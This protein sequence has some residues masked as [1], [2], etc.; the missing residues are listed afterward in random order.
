MR[1]K[2]WRRYESLSIRERYTARPY[3]ASVTVTVPNLLF[4]SGLN[5]NSGT[6]ADCADANPGV[7]KLL[8]YRPGAERHVEQPRL[9]QAPA[10]TIGRRR[11]SKPV[12]RPVRCEVLLMPVP[13][14]FQWRH[15]VYSQRHSSYSLRLGLTSPVPSSPKL[16]R[17]LSKAASHNAER[18]R[19]L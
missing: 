7:R 2:R 6:G 15:M 17:P 1:G 12:A 13:Q 8:R 18:R 16:T 19:P 4:K 9:A 3:Q 14:S 10:C 11:S 5:C